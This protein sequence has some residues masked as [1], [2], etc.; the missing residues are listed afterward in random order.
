MPAALLM[1]S[2]QARVQVLFEEPDDLA[3]KIGRLNKAICAKCPD[4]RFITFFMAIA[5]PSSGELVFT[6]AGHNPPL[7]VR[8]AGGFETLKGG[9]VILGI[10]PMATYQESRVQLEPGDI[11]VLFSDGVTEAVNPQDEDFGDDRLANLVKSLSDRPAAEIVEAIDSAVT[12][13]T[14]GAP[15]AD[16]ITVVVVRR[17]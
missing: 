5:D 6:N 4:N 10:L 7:V 14:Q 17:V 2:L 13:F 3:R 11:L 8:A 9:G 1:S 16:D 15:A 12:E